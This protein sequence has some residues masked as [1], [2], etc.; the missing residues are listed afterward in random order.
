MQTNNITTEQ[1]IEHEVQIRLLNAKHEDFRKEF[2]SIGRK[3]D[4]LDSKIESGF[5]LLVG[6]IITSIILPVVL[7]SLKLV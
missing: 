7:H 6:L 1:Y 2:E 4:K 3:F 5:L